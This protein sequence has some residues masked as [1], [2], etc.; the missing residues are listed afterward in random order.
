MSFNTTI[1]NLVYSQAT[2]P[3]N[4]AEKPFV[5]KEWTNPIFDTNTSASY[6]SNQIIFD[7]TTLAN[8]GQ[9]PNYSEGMIILPMVI[10]VSASANNDWTAA[11]RAGTDFILALKNS[12][13]Q[14]VH[15]IGINMNNMD[16]IQPV[17]LSNAYLTFIQHS[18]LST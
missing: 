13:V 6:N 17:P 8:S 16:I 2:Q 10:R 1:D 12:H 3:E 18:E 14:L 7:S 5:S 9:F 15:S 11:G 4:I